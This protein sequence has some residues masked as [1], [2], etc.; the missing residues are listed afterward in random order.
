MALG[1]D[2]CRRRHRLA[3]GLQ[4]VRQRAR[5]LARLGP[6][7]RDALGVGASG[8]AAL[9]RQRDSLVILLARSL[10]QRLVRGILDQR[11]LDRV[12]AF[13]GVDEALA[14]ELLDPDGEHP[15]FVREDFAQQL[16]RPV[17]P[18]RGAELHHLLGFGRHPVEPRHQQ[19]LQRRGHHRVGQ[20]PGELVG[21]VGLAQ[22]P[23]IEEHPRHFLDVERI[24]VGLRDQQRHHLRRQRLVA[25]D[26]ADHRLGVGRRQLIDVELGE[27]VAAEPGRCES[28]P[29]RE[30][31]QQP[32]LRQLREHAAKE[33]ERASRRPSAGPRRRAASASCRRAPSAARRARRRSSASA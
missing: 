27:A 29:R 26:T 28:R 1:L 17:A 22:R 10:Q 8:R 32:A 31:Q 21:G 5:R 19:V 9:Q 33:L 6:V 25:D 2:R 15:R 3:P 20:R 24:A 4:P 14:D 7:L 23:R 11:V 13:R 30:Q 16:E 18:D 12:A